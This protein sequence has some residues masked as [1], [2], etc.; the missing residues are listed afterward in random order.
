MDD[1]RLDRIE[2]A[3]LRHGS[4]RAQSVQ[5]PQDFTARIMREVRNKAPRSVSFWD[6][7]GIAARRFAPV[8]ALA[9]T[10]ACGYA[11]FM[12]RALHQAVLSL[13]M[14]GAGAIT[15]AGLVP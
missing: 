15:L 10:A 8:G 6:L 4:L 9:A 14:H 1:G 12:E 5:L 3:L 2:Q 7:F 13:S 11:Q